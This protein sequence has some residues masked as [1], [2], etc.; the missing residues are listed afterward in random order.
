[1]LTCLGSEEED[2]FRFCIDRGKEE[3]ILSSVN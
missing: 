2:I 1:M 3:D